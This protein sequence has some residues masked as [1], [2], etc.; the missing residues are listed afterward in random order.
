M[1]LKETL[2][3]IPATA[4]AGPIADTDF[5]FS[6]TSSG[7]TPYPTGSVGPFVIILDRGNVGEE[8][9]LCS[10]RTSDTFTVV[11]STGRGHDGSTAIAHTTGVTVEHGLDALS[12]QEFSDHINKTDGADLWVTN[13][14]LDATTKAQ[15]A[16][17]DTNSGLITTNIAD[18]ATNTADIATNVTNIGTNT[19][20]IGV[21]LPP[22]VI[23]DYAAATAPTGWL[24]CEGTAVSRT[25]YSALFAVI[26]TGF[27]AGDGSSTF[28]V[29]D[30]RDRV[31]VG[32][33][34]TKTL[35]AAAGA[36]TV[37]LATGNLPSHAHTGAVHTHAGPSHAHTFSDTS[38]SAGAADVELRDGSGGTKII[39][40]DG[41]AAGLGLTGSSPSITDRAMVTTNSTLNG[42]TRAI[43]PIS[44]HAHDVSGTTGYSGTANTG[45]ASAANTGNAGS[46]TA[47]SIQQKYLVVAKIIKT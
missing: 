46:G 39:T 40:S 44:N 14:K 12:I 4:L 8:T 17:A 22:G 34:G 37:T 19:T 32:Q 36:D 7:G 1:A 2:G 27:G 47:V 9:V 15:V 41:E 21:G 20:A 10:G 45:A 23:F 6:V 3:S 30:Y 33:S 29:P 43:A 26:G 38:T 35:A 28:N 13:R 5:T 42:A 24:L 16:L 25:T 18:I 11:A 31:A